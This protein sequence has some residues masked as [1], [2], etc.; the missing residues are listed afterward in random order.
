MPHVVQSAI[1]DWHSRQLNIRFSATV[2]ICE[3]IAATVGP[4]PAGYCSDAAIGTCSNFAAA[5]NRSMFH[6]TM[7]C[8]SISGKSFSCTSTTSKPDC[9]RSSNRG[10]RNDFDVDAG[11]FLCSFIAASIQFAFE[12]LNACPLSNSAHFSKMDIQQLQSGRG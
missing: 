5:S 10:L 12:R 9:C 1:S 7:A 8:R 2:S 3:R 11:V 6:C 4:S